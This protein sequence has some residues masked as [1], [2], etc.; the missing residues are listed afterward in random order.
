MTL[1]TERSECPSC[2]SSDGLAVDEVGFGYCFSCK[3]RFKKEELDGTK[4]IPE[5]VSRL[6]S[7]TQRAQLKQV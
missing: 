3:K 5:A 4:E 1:K 2:Q 7:V 6:D